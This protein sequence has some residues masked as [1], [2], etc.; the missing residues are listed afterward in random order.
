MASS[1]PPPPPP[2]Q[3]AVEHGRE[4]CPDRILDDIG[5]AF[6]M[7]ALGGGAWH[8]YKGLKNSPKGYKLIGA[9]ETVRRESPRIGGNF[10]NWGLMFSVFDCTCLYVRKKVRR[11][12][13][14]W[15]RANAAA[16]VV[17][18]LARA[19]NPGNKRPYTPPASHPA[20]HPTNQPP[21]PPTPKTK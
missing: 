6:G 5:G 15:Q 3:Q 21:P 16:V 7:G 13:S 10:A 17:V 8:M 1:Y 20:N 18:V 11:C 12:W 4:P 14:A 9:I 19:P 2:P